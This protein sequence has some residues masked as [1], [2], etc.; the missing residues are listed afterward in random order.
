VAGIANVYSNEADRD[1]P[2][3]QYCKVPMPHFVP[4]SLGQPRHESVIKF[5]VAR[6]YETTENGPA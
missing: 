3:G 1:V 2:A 4:P 5:A 6:S